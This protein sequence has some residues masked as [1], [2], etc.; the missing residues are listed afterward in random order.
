MY[1][2]KLRHGAILGCAFV[3]SISGGS[4]CSFGSFHYTRPDFHALP[5]ATALVRAANFYTST[6]RV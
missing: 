1:E 5:S 3:F 4:N 6:S 2:L